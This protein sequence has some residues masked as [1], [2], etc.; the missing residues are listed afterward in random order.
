MNYFENPRESVFSVAVGKH[1]NAMFKT[2]DCVT[3][4]HSKR[5]EDE[6]YKTPNGKVEF[7]VDLSDI[8]YDDIGD[9]MSIRLP[10]EYTLEFG[11]SAGYIW[12]EDQSGKK[13]IYLE[14]ARPKVVE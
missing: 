9:S 14:Y 6:D 3:I 2:I 12:L 8:N 13:L 4:D 5:R 11:L 7:F 10:N 1:G